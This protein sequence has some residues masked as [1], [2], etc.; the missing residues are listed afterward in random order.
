MTRDEFTIA[1]TH[2]CLP[3]HFPGNPV[4]PGVVLID[5]V[6]KAVH[7]AEDVSVT[8]VK[9]C[10]FVRPLYP[11][12]ICTVEWELQEQNIKFVCCDTEGILARGALQ[13]ADG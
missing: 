7:A 11:D 2:P 4:V 13:T 6:I 8:G 5:H 10:K 9:R 12:C 3:G 1:A